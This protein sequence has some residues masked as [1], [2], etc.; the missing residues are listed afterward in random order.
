MCV[1]VCVCAC[2]CMCVCMCV[3]ACVC[4]GTERVIL[5][6]LDDILE[7]SEEFKKET[8]DGRDIV[9][10]DIFCGDLNFDNISP[11][12]F[13]SWQICPFVFI[14][15]KTTISSHLDFSH[16]KYGWFSPFHSH[17]PCQFFFLNNR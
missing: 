6:Q 7:W 8:A 9:L 5:R 14:F 1:C 4:A 11:G 13:A 16:G 3:C 15:F 17:C 10:F 2:V 12:Q